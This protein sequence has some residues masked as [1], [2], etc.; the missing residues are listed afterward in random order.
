MSNIQ[1]IDQHIIINVAERIE[2]LIKD[3]RQHIN[4]IVDITEVIT[5]YEIGHVIIEVVQEGEDRA[6]YGKQLLK[7]VSEIL[8]ERL[9]EGWSVD[10]LK[11]CRKFYQIYVAKIIYFDHIQLEIIYVRRYF[12]IYLYMYNINI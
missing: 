8:T 5:K 6:R 7:G 1:N 10:T 3:A 2:R 11:K 9:G 4:R 12:N